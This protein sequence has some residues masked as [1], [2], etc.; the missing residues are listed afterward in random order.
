MKMKRAAT[1]DKQLTDVQKSWVRCEYLLSGIPNPFGDP[2]QEKRAFKKLNPGAIPKT[3]TSNPA[4][5]LSRKKRL[6][7]KTGSLEFYG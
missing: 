2:E 1:Q 5:G 3:E 6:R 7:M 4:S